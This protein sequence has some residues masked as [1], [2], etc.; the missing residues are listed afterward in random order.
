MVIV[1]C[2]KGSYAHCE[3]V[4]HAN[5]QYVYSLTTFFLMTKEFCFLS[6]MDCVHELRVLVGSQ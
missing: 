3:D 6:R 5:E 4:L 2:F 1:L